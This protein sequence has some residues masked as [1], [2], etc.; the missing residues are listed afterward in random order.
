MK[1]LIILYLAIVS[2]YYKTKD[3]DNG[4]ISNKRIKT[5]PNFKKICEAKES[6]RLCTLEE[7]KNAE[8]CRVTG[9]KEIMYCT[10][11][12]GERLDNDYYSTEP[13]ESDKINIV[14]LYLMLFF[15]TG[16]LSLLMRKYYRKMMLQSTLNKITIIKDK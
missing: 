8:E 15:T 9:Y 1:I 4:Q 10:V 14:Y 12:D 2:C 6:C 7:L 11:Y 5:N 13:C 16:V 3:I